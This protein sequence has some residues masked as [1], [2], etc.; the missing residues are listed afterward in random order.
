MVESLYDQARRDIQKP[1]QPQ[2]N[3]KYDNPEKQTQPEPNP[4]ERLSNVAVTILK[5][6]DCV[7]KAKEDKQ[8]I[9]LTSSQFMQ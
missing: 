2:E 3:N 7:E 6:A 8:Q 5:A 9:L 1:Y 4:P